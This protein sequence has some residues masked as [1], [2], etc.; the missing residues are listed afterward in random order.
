MP[1]VNVCG[2]STR[3]VANDGSDASPR[4]QT[5]GLYAQSLA[6]VESFLADEHILA[7]AQSPIPPRFAVRIDPRW[8][9]EIR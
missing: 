3:G 8:R 7:E 5:I 2:A 6:A 4:I 9:V 1:T